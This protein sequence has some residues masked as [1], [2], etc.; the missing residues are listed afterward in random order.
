M[1]CLIQCFLRR[2]SYGQRKVWLLSNRDQNFGTFDVWFGPGLP[3]A[4]ILPAVPMVYL[5]N[6]NQ[7]GMYPN[8]SIMLT[9][10]KCPAAIEIWCGSNPN[11]PHGL[12]LYSRVLVQGMPSPEDFAWYRLFP[13]NQPDMWWKSTSCELQGL[14]SHRHEQPAI[15]MTPQ[16]R[17]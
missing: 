5:G 11:E 17:L 10:T 2:R 7:Y 9:S 12:D 13:E 3:L 8:I 14:K 16:T 15:R 1:F 6:L 4:M